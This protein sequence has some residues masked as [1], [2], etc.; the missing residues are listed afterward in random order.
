MHDLAR[1]LPVLAVSCI[2]ATLP[3]LSA[4]TRML[5]VFGD[6]TGTHF[7]STVANAGDIDRD[8]IVDFIVG[9]PSQNL[10]VGE[11]RVFSGRDGRILAKLS[12]FPNKKAQF[13][14][15]VASAGDFDVDGYPDVIVCS[16]VHDQNGKDSGAVQVFSGRDASVLFTAFGSGPGDLFGNGAAAIGD[17]DND[18]HPDLVVGAPE[19][20][21]NPVKDYG[22]GYARVFSGRS[23]TVLRTISGVKLMDEYGTAVAAAGDVDKD[24]IPDFVVGSNLEGG[25]KGSARA[26][27]GR[28]F[29]VIHNFPPDPLGACFGMSVGGGGDADG[30]GYLDVV[31]GAVNLGQSIRPAVWV[32]SGRT[33]KKIH[34]IKAGPMHGMTGMSVGNAGDLDNDG[35]DDFFSGFPMDSS[36]AMM[37]GC[38]RYFSGKNGS[39]LFVPYGI[40]MGSG[41]GMSSAVLGDLNGD[42]RIEVVIG[43]TNGKKGG[44]SVGSMAVVSLASV[45]RTAPGCAAGTAPPTLDASHVAVGKTT[46]VF[47]RGSAGQSGLLFLSSIPDVPLAIVPGCYIYLD[48]ASML[49]LSAVLTDASGRWSRAF[50]VPSSNNLIGFTFALQGATGSAR[51]PNYLE[52]SNGVLATVGR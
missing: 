6:T 19:N 40:G 44:Q 3:T 35:H 12:G 11:A 46:T 26:Y 41:F 47:L 2:L 23:G 48:V 43:A 17:I 49:P 38:V 20:G 28:T 25:G 18:G 52:L 31:V 4:Q 5:R 8:G 34:Q 24:G 14:S 50:A 9:I 30:D 10:G 42:G 7:G 36:G 33:G 39:E 29:G 37:G 21:G 16:V 27:S 13:G 1:P 22:N 45:A 32:F 51:G 15:R